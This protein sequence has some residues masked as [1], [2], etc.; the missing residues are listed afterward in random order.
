MQVLE[1]GASSPVLVLLLCYLQCHDI[2]G[3]ALLARGFLIV[4]LVEK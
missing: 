4:D 2:V 3:S 1:L